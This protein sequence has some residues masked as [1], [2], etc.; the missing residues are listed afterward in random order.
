LY[1]YQNIILNASR[2][3]KSVLNE[4]IKA[5]SHFTGMLKTDSEGNAIF[6]F[7]EDG[8]QIPKT[9][10]NPK[11]G[12][13]VSMESDNGNTAS[14]EYIAY[15]TQK[16]PEQKNPEFELIFIPKNHTSIKKIINICDAILNIKK[17]S[18][19]DPEILDLVLKK[20]GLS[21]KEI[22]VELFNEINK[23]DESN[24]IFR[25]NIE[26]FIE[27]NPKLN[28]F[29]LNALEEGFIDKKH[30]YKLE[31]SEKKDVYNE[32]IINIYDQ[33][34]EESWEFETKT[35]GNKDDNPDFS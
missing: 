21:D 23:Y 19:Q 28:E 29:I 8:N 18:T 5:T 1:R 2:I 6:E 7:L 24:G 27:L 11:K 34:Y 13:F 10:Y 20:H 32:P 16:S 17:T 30:S 4:H 31:V 14:L 35:L 22:V 3:D 25:I 12:R 9:E 33:Q 15:K 26:N